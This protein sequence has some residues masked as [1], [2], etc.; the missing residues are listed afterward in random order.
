MK[1]VLYN[2]VQDIHTEFYLLVNMS[3]NFVVMAE[4]HDENTLLETF[5]KEL[6]KTILNNGLFITPESWISIW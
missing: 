2:L 6:S 5:L 4:K 1:S 3:R